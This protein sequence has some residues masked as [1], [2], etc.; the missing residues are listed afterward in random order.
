MAASSSEISYPG[1]YTR[2]L[3]FSGSSDIR[4]SVPPRCGE[5]KDEVLISSVN[6]IHGTAMPLPFDPN[7]ISK[8]DV[9]SF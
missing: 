6:S 4:A 9:R 3:Q 5:L 7:S 8:Q 1:L 2:R